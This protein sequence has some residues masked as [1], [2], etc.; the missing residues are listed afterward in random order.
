MASQYAS[1]FG[2]MC[3]FF[4]P[5]RAFSGE[6]AVSTSATGPEAGR[7]DPVVHGSTTDEVSCDRDG[8]DLVANVPCV[9]VLALHRDPDILDQ[10]LPVR[11]AARQEWLARKGFAL[12]I[13]PQGTASTTG[14]TV[15]TDV[16]NPGT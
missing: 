5:F 2:L 15:P 9:L 11:V 10:E 4:L 7:T 13:T 6:P 12:R 16:T 1:A 14:G 8:D 3:L